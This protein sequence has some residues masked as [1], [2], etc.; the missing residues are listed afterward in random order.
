MLICGLFAIIMPQS[1]TDLLNE[2]F[3]QELTEITTTM[4]SVNRELHNFALKQNVFIELYDSNGGYMGMF[5]DDSILNNLTTGETDVINSE[6]ISDGMML[7]TMTLTPTEFKFYI[8]NNV[9]TLH[10]FGTATE[11]INEVT[12]ILQNTIP[13]IIAFMIIISLIVA[14]FLSRFIT[15]P[16]KA[17]NESAKMIAALSFDV[18]CEENR[19]DELGELAKNIN[20]LSAKLDDA[21]SSLQDELEKE[22]ALEESQRLFFSAASHE[23][24][25]PLTVIKG[26]LEGMIYGYK[27]YE[28][29]DAYIAKT[30]RTATQMEHLISE[31]LTFSTMGGSEYALNTET[32]NLCDVIDELILHFAEIIEIKSFEVITDLENV[33]VTADKKLLTKAVQNIISNA[34]HYSPEQQTIKITLTDKIL[35]V[36][37]TGIAIS[38]EDISKLFEPFYRVDKSRSRQTGGSGL[39]LHFVK[40]ILE[41]H[42]LD[43]SITS[44]DNSVKFTILL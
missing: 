20:T 9:Y 36:E 16:I 4:S 19:S 29:K 10:I 35:V 17:I 28:D 30:L 23:L 43:F 12:V 37:N 39:G 2:N 13:I 14:L 42:N 33:T 6:H 15:K 40:T 27:D 31:I 41:K 21:L 24:K 7:E 18:H 44:G 5:G 22:K 25:T 11:S 34:L 3:E 1:Y 26:N 32:F 38:S 8:D